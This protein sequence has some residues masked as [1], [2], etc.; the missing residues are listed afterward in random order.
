MKNHKKAKK[1]NHKWIHETET[2]L[3]M[4]K[5]CKRIHEWLIHRCIKCGKVSMSNKLE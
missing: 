4:N 1:H 5:R 3:C 2:G